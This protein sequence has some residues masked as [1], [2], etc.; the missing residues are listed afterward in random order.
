[1]IVQRQLA[2]K[3]LEPTMGWT[4]ARV[5][6]LERIA[7]LFFQSTILFMQL[8]D[9]LGV[10]IQTQH[11]LLRVAIAVVVLKFIELLVDPA[12]LVFFLTI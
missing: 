10:F 6:S 12:A 5:G 1:M 9:R 4:A 8:I 2:N 11:Q 7:N 3:Q